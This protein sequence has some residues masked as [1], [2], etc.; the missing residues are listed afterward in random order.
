MQLI[1][2]LLIKVQQ[3]KALADISKEEINYKKNNQVL[4]GRARYWY[5]ESTA[6]SS[7]HP[8]KS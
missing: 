1:L 3:S 6:C 7:T 5:T 8:T 2:E 4:Q